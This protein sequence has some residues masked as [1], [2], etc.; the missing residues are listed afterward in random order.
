MRVMVIGSGGREH[1]LVRGLAASAKVREVLT[2]G[3]NAGTTDFG[4][5]IRVDLSD[6]DALV[7][8][9]GERSVD[10]TVV[11]PEAPLCAGI[12]DKFNAAGLRVFGPTAAAARIEGDKA[13]FAT[14]GAG[15][16]NRSGRR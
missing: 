4:E 15:Q 1:A 10:L 12:V 9:A 14:I 13:Y 3:G 6:L 7:E 5:K 8:L 2:A 16:Q 11:G